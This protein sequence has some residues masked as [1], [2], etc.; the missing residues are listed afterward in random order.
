MVSA[1]FDK[2][3]EQL[4]SNDQ[5]IKIVRMVITDSCILF[6]RSFKMLFRPSLLPLVLCFGFLCISTFYSLTTVAM[7]WPSAEDVQ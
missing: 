7:M 4:R 1:S 6:V 5:K 2:H 3:K